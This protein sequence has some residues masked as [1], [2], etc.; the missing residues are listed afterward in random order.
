MGILISTYTHSLF[1]SLSLS[2]YLSLSL[3]L[4]LSLSIYLSLFHPSMYFNISINIP[5]RADK[6]YKHYDL[7][8]HAFLCLLLPSQ[9]TLKLT[10]NIII[11]KTYTQL[12]PSVVSVSYLVRLKLVLKQCHLGDQ[13][14][15]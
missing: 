9:I 6:L 5:H 12:T 1:L 4:Y 11:N 2:L 7:F 14:H 15:F 3:S 10:S 8:L 13:E